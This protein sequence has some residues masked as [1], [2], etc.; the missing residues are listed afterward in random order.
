MQKRE[1]EIQLKQRAKKL[2]ASLIKNMLEQQIGQESKFAKLRA[3]RC[4]LT[5]VEIVISVTQSTDKTINDFI[6]A[7]NKLPEH[8]RKEIGIKGDEIH[9]S[10]IWQMVKQEILDYE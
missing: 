10:S 5:T 4:A 7:F 1:T 8:I 3:K 2:A 9:V 6:S